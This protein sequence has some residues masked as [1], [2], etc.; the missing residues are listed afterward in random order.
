MIESVNNERVKYWTKLNEKKYQKAEKLFLV[1]GEHLVY[2]ALKSQHL[3]EV[4]VLNGYDFEYDKKTFVSENVMRKISN[5]TNI[6]KLVGVVK[7]LE[8]REINGNVLMLDQVSDPGNLGTI[9]RSSVAFGIDTIILG[10]GCVSVYN[11]KVVRATEGQMFHLNI[12]ERHLEQAIEDLRSEGYKIYATDVE[13]GET[14]YKT[15]FAP[16]TAI[17]MGNE[18]AGVSSEIKSMSDE[19]LYI[20]MNET[21]E[22]LNVGVATSIILYELYM[23]SNI[24]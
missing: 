11:P 3:K 15:D 16:K 24:Q 7:M 13:E 21:C 5:L 18:G 1:E 22:S 14:L 6:P 4:I 19:Y 23:K 20:E 9:I 8:E 12:I 2:E 10:R 17:V